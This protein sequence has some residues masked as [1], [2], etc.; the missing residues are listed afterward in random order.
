MESLQRR[1]HAS[2][3]KLFS[4]EL[5]GEEKVTNAAPSETH[6]LLAVAAAPLLS[7]A[8]AFSNLQTSKLTY[9]SLV[10][11]L[12]VEPCSAANAHLPYST[13]RRRQGPDAEPSPAITTPPKQNRVSVQ[14]TTAVAAHWL[15]SAMQKV[16]KYE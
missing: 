16:P 10:C 14:T 12:Q 4:K 1:L 11:Q 15:F 13:R 3:K 8:V 9:I 7:S 2:E 6:F 5:E